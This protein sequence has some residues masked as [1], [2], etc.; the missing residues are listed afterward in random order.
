MTELKL[1]TILE[2][3]SDQAS[4]SIRDIRIMGGIERFMI[5]VTG[6]DKIF[7]LT[8]TAGGAGRDV[9]DD[10]DLGVR[11]LGQGQLVVEP[12]EL[13]G[14]VPGGGQ[15]PQVQ[16]VTEVTVQRDESQSRRDLTQKRQ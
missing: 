10:V 13:T 6:N 14:G 3:C 5:Y 9:R 7:P 15:Q 1:A 4:D 11:G 2:N 8:E 16:I 12:E